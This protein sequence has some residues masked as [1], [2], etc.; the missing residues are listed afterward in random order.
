L[1]VNQIVIFTPYH[2][3]QNYLP[4][5]IYAATIENN[6][7]DKFYII[8]CGLWQ[9]NSRLTHCRNNASVT[10][11]PIARTNRYGCRGNG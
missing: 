10:R 6:F 2:Q 4:G 8:T 3:R 5:D 7:I 9:R 11:D 1:P